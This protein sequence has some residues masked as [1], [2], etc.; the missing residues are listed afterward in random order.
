MAARLSCRVWY[1]SSRNTRSDLPVKPSTLRC[2][3]GPTIAAVAFCPHPPLLV[4]EIAAGA[5]TETESLRSACDEAVRR[6]VAAGPSQ[7]VILG[8]HGP[9]A[10]LRGFAPDL[11]E[12]PDDQL[13]LSL[14]IGDW[15]VRRQ[16]H[17]PSLAYVSVYPDGSPVAAWPDMAARTGL[18]V[19]ADGSAR[20]SLKGPG[21]LD[22]R[23]ETF[24]EAVVAALIDADADAL[25]TF[26]GE[27]AAELL[28]GGIGVWKAFGTAFGELASARHSGQ[29]M[30]WKT[31]LLYADAP[32]G[33]MYI[34]ASWLPA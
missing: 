31:D 27:L 14:S 13:P 21:Y 20:R 4:P 11:A 23:A 8:A 16:G 2:V 9:A 5:A 1:A 19:M 33:V 18:L 34:V 25:A 12:L 28:V 17:R 10:G 24:D 3:P 7:I 22:P 32:F 15:L 6:L 29:R 26:D 30:E